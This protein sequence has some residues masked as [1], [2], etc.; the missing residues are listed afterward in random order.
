MSDNETA[1][2]TNNILEHLE[3]T[4]TLLDISVKELRAQTLR[5]NKSAGVR[6]RKVLRA[7]K[8]QVHDI[9][10]SSNKWGKEE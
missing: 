2:E 8:H 7:L 5:G 9:I 10:K 4:R 1:E 3:E 6:G